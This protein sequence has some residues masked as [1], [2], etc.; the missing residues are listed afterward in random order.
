M[1][2]RTTNRVKGMNADYSYSFSKNL[3]YL[4]LEY[5]YTL[6]LLYMLGSRARPRLKWTKCPAVRNFHRISTKSFIQTS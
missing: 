6:W 5:L 1:Q 2:M 4:V 3:R